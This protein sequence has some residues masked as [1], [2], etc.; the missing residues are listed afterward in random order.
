MSRVRLSLNVA[1]DADVFEMD[2]IASSSNTF[3]DD[4]TSAFFIYNPARIYAGY[5]GIEMTSTAA[6]SISVNT[7]GYVG[8]VRSNARYLYTSHFLPSGDARRVEITVF[9]R[10]EDELPVGSS[11]YLQ[12]ED[13]GFVRSDGWVKISFVVT[14]PNNTDHVFIKRRVL[15]VDADET[16]WT[17]DETFEY[18]GQD[19]GPRI[20]TVQ[21]SMGRNYER[22]EYEAGTATFVLKNEDGLLTPN[23]KGSGFP[24]QDNIKVKRSVKYFLVK[25]GCLYPRWSGYSSRWEQSFPGSRYATVSLECVDMFRFLSNFQLQPP[26]QQEVLY[27]NPNA[28]FPMNEGSETLVAGNI[29]GTG[30]TIELHTGKYGD[31]GTKFGA[32]KMLP[33]VEREIF[34]DDTADDNS[35]CVDFNPNALNG[36]VRNFIFTDVEVPGMV[37]DVNGWAVEMWLIPGTESPAIEETIFATAIPGNAGHDEVSGFMI[38]Q[39]VFG[40]LDFYSGAGLLGGTTEN[41]RVTTATHLVFNYRP[42]GTYGTVDIYINGSNIAG[43][44]L[45]LSA[46]PFHA[47]GPPTRAGFGGYIDSFVDASVSWYVGRGGHLAFYDHYLTSDRVNAH[48]IVGIY[49]GYIENEGNRLG[50]LANFAGVPEWKRQIDAGLV[51]LADRNWSATS[52]LSLM[53]KTTGFAAGHLFCGVDGKLT[54]RNR[55]SRTNTPLLATFDGIKSVLWQGYAPSTDDANFANVAIV[56]Q[57]NGTAVVARDETSILENGEYVAAPKEVELRYASDLFSLAQLLVSDYADTQTRLDS[58][59]L[60]PDQS[61][62]QWDDCLRLQEGEKIR[63]GNL[64][65]VTPDYSITEDFSTFDANKWGRDYPAQILFTGGRLEITTLTG[66]VSFQTLFTQRPYNIKNSSY[67]VRVIDVGD[68]DIVTYQFFPL[69]ISDESLEN[70]HMFVISNG[71]I[72]SLYLV[73]YSNFTQLRVDTYDPLVHVYLRLR[74]DSN[75]I[76][77]EYSSNGL[78]WTTFSITSSNV[79]ATAVRLYVRAGH[80]G[81]ESDTTRAIVDDMNIYPTASNYLDVFVEK[82]EEKRE[83][84]GRYTWQLQVSPVK[85]YRFFA[86]LN[87]EVYG[88]L[89]SQYCVL[90]Y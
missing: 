70:Q 21:T 6:G 80:F 4:N 63:V 12:M 56:Q 50:G 52:A 22:D 57:P 83:Q 87:D 66:S 41:Y 88:Q 25:D 29:S 35:T 71:N 65:I 3:A 43:F 53:Q 44:G 54:Y 31:S 14:T 5:T 47:L 64:P 46:S 59:L 26:Y 28:Y 69:L 90:G 13:E 73:D 61:E 33:E 16:H 30:G 24:Y 55:N 76:Y 40:S 17:D 42:G 67:G 8:T 9:Y 7:G 79:D 78:D 11:V 37:P 45:E 32:D 60:D 23:G 68:Q 49:G 84:N 27:D 81:T 10:S 72:Y 89:N 77:Y 1:F 48:F 86:R 85:Q 82:I 36:T 15:G 2:G 51:T 20:Q 34:G 39:N 74:E 62:I 18:I 19:I 75:V 58:V 38:K